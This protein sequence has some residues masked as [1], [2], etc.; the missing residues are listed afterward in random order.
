MTKWSGVFAAAG[1]IVLVTAS[2]P[3]VRAIPAFSRKYETS[4]ITCHV[5]P[6]KLNAFGHAFK[7][8]GYRMPERDEDLIRQKQ[9]SLGAPAW[10]K[11]WPKT[12]WPAD[13]PGGNFFAVEFKTSFT[14]NPGARVTNE[15]DGLGEVSLLMGGTIGES[16]SFF[17]DLNLFE[18]G[19]PGS[20][21]R[22]YLQYN[23]PS[24]WFNITLGQFQP[25][26]EPFVSDLSLTGSTEYLTNIF[27][28]TSTGNFFGFVPNQKGIE[29][30]GGREGPKG[31]GGVMWS[32]GVVNGELGSAADDLADVP[33]LSEQ[34]ADLKT[35][36]RAHGG[37]FDIN[38][39]KDF[40]FQGSY[41][42]LGMGVIG[43]GTQSTL[44]QTNNWRDDSLT[45]GAY[46]Y[47]GTTA[48]FL[49]GGGDKPVFDAS[50]N[51]FY[52]AGAT[53]DWWFKDLNVLG[54]WQRNHDHLRNGVRA[55]ARIFTAEGN[56]V[57]PWPWIQPAARVEIIKPDFGRSFNRTTLSTT[58]LIRANILL[59][60]QGF[61]ASRKVPQWPFFDEQFRTTLRFLF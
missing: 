39:G 51:T 7:N 20:I 17:A 26:A 11:V 42:I 14:V 25:R 57:C 2:S 28:M 36:I 40:Y 46:F 4:C 8:R 49:A 10:K 34:I 30:W 24:H 33:E 53:F 19:N 1:A 21:G 56:Y 54:G 22:A 61:L 12:V 58:V 15:F 27:P 59:T 23:H 37:R 50:G 43:S 6:P 13:I 18:S 55:D 44:A 29:F 9:V 41:K 32:A 16:A 5:A 45:L 31:K 48:A 3:P 60:L 52:R 38:S 47:R 35:Q